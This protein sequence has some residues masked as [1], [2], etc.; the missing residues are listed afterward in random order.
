MDWGLLPCMY[1]IVLQYFFF[2]N[3]IEI[4]LNNNSNNDG[5]RDVKIQSIIQYKYDFQ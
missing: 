1:H 2:R 4:Q 3:F 5:I